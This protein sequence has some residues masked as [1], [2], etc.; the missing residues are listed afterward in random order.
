LELK[1]LENKNFETWRKQYLDHLGIAVIPDFHEALCQMGQ[2]Y[3]VVEAGRACGYIVYAKE[4]WKA[5][6]GSIIPEF[7]FSVNS[8]RTCKQLLGEVFR[9]LRPASIVGRTDDRAGFPLLMDLRLRN[10]V[11]SPL[12]VLEKAPHW[13]ENCDYSIIEST[14][15]DAQ[16]LLPLYASVSPE[17]GG[18]PDETSLVKSLAAWRH[19]RLIV[20]GGEI[21]AAAYAVPQGGRHISVVPI[22]APKFRGQGMGRYLMA[23]ALNREMN[24]N[25][26]CVI[27]VNA[28]NE[29]GKSLVESLGARLASYF[30]HFSVDAI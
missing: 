13:L 12:Y 11:A 23:F 30:V 15:D 18:I 2:A 1:I 8:V 27:T 29:A 5:E 26:I 6:W 4:T 25:K 17:D 3:E 19:Y 22:V 14:P 16:R 21:A 9:K 28:D 24:E 10:Q 7:Y 20:S